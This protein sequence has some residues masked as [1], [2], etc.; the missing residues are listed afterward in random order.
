VRRGSLRLDAGIRERTRLTNP[1]ETPA[2][3]IQ[4]DLTGFQPDLTGSAEAD[5][6]FVLFLEILS[7]PGRYS[8]PT[9]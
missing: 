8:I 7:G 6:N 9:L 2:H 5:Q 4:P 3:G 1:S